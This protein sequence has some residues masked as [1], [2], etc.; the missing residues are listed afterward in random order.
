MDLRED[1]VTYNDLM[2]TND[3]AEAKASVRKLEVSQMNKGRSS[4]DSDNDNLDDD[5]EEKK[6]RKYEYKTKKGESIKHN[7]EAFKE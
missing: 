5:P 7:V 3:L 1:Y 2:P 4:N 6:K